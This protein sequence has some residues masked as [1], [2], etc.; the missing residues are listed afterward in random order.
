MILLFFIYFII[1]AFLAG[2]VGEEEPG[3]RAA[4]VMLWPIW[5]FLILLVAILDAPYEL[6]LK[7]HDRNKEKKQ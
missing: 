3:W 5:I 2:V 1:G 4:F 6:G 7:L